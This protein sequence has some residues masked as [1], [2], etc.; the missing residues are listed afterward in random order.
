[1]GRLKAGWKLSFLRRFWISNFLF[2]NHNH[3]SIILLG[4]FRCGPCPVAA[5]KHCINVPFD[6]RFLY[7]AVDGDVH[8]LIIRN[9]SVVGKKVDIDCVGELIYTKSVGSNS[10][11]NLTMMYKSPKCNASNK[12]CVHILLK[13]SDGLCVRNMSTFCVPFSKGHKTQVY[14]STNWVMVIQ[15][16]NRL[17]SKLICLFLFHCTVFIL[18]LLF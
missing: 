10:P 3:E 8:R 4:T 2:L 14:L 17:V 5:I 1:M 16:P 12:S 18:V 15:E 9:G 7:A 13:T 11:Q 6:T